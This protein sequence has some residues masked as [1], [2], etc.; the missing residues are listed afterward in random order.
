MKADMVYSKMIA[1]RHGTE[2]QQSHISEHSETSDTAYSKVIATRNG[3]E[4]QQL[5]ISEHT[6]T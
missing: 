3:T 4:T 1:T 5:H 2:T 6:E